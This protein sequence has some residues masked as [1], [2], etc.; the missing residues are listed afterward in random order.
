[1]LSFTPAAS[2]GMLDR[3]FVA[4]VDRTPKAASRKMAQSLNLNFACTC[5]IRIRADTSGLATIPSRV[6]TGGQDAAFA[7]EKVF[8]NKWLRS[9]GDCMTGGMFSGGR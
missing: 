1:M 4:P 9:F 2:M 6:Q 8:N 7:F 5:V 3:P